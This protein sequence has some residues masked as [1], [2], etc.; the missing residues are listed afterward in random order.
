MEET[1]IDIKK[2][3]INPRLTRKLRKE[4]QGMESRLSST[5][6]RIGWDEK[7]DTRM[8][9]MNNN[10]FLGFQHCLL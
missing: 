6:S 9:I 7:Q 10:L 5:L 8:N 2:N 4:E 3:M 1:A